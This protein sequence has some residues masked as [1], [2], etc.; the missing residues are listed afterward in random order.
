[1]SI[2]DEQGFIGDVPVIECTWPQQQP[3]RDR[4]QFLFFGL[5][6][7]STEVEGQDN[8]ERNIP[9]MT[10]KSFSDL[11]NCRWNWW[12]HTVLQNSVNQIVHFISWTLYMWWWTFGLWQVYISKHM[13]NSCDILMWFFICVIYWLFKEYRHLKHLLLVREQA[14]RL[15]AFMVVYTKVKTES[16][17]MLP[18]VNVWV[19]SKCVWIAWFSA[20]SIHYVMSRAVDPLCHVTCSW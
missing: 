16:L 2:I 7:A 4:K 11:G 9:W 13:N 5:G 10:K 8:E 15:V 14:R 17:F 1:M 6:E 19:D 20:V 3:T 12:R 18:S